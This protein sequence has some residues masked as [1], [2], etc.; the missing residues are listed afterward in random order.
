MN[1]HRIAQASLI[2]AVVA[3]AVTV[4]LALKAG[5]AY[6]GVVPAA[7]A[8]VLGFSASRQSS[9][10]GT[11]RPRSALVGLS[12]GAL[13]TTAVAVWFAGLLLLFVLCAP[14]NEC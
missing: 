2:L 9:Q 6:L 3:T 4:L 10:V 7:S 14:A 11:K 13:I 12:I 1:A 8:V 5:P